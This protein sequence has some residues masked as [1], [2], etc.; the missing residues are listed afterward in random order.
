[1]LKV[2]NIEV[3]YGGVIRVLHGV[4]IKVN[5]RSIVATLGSNGAGKTTLLKAIS[6][7]L[8]TEE[9]KVTGGSIEFR[10]VRI[11]KLEPEVVARM[12][13]VQAMEGRRLF[14]HLGVEDNLMVGAYINR[15]PS[16]TKKMLELVYRYFPRLKDLRHKM[17]GYLSG[18]EQQMLVIG[19]SMMSEPEIILFDEPCLGLAPLVARGIL[20]II[21]RLN[22]EQKI[23]VLL[24]E[25]NAHAALSI[26]AYA[27]VLENGKIVLDG[28]ADK[29]RINEDIKEFYFGFI[30]GGK[31]KSFR[32]VKQYR[33][34]KRWLV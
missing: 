28:P 17:S 3:V 31:Q 7:L 1:V 10:G 24:V 13:I 18:G 16:A 14:A 20:S 2:N 6:G 12:R 9:G 11:D 32:E 15:D 34:R 29:L 19:Q 8:K 4:S 25:Q 26:A 5:E 23:T 30:E 27:Y 21:T 33:R 22:G